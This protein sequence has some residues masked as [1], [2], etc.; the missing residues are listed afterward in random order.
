MK[1]IDGTVRSTVNYINPHDMQRVI[2]AIPQ[3]NIRKWLDKDIE[4]LFK[5]QY[6]S[7]LRPMEAITLEKHQINLEDRKINL[8]KT[9]TTAIDVAMIPKRFVPELAKWLENKPDGQRLWIDLTY[10]TF[11][12]HLLRLGKLCNIEAWTTPQ[13][14]T[15]EKTIGHIWR[16]SQAKA[17]LHGDILNN[18]GE[19]FAIPI[20]SQHLRHKNPAVTINSYL[21]SSIEAVLDE[22]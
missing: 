13:S 17:Q 12:R 8:G 10:N 11:Y 20:I 22:Y 21:K 3:L 4:M 5:I 19:K 9:K 2:D 18:K 6:N 15:G 16:K 7:A 1:N 14:V